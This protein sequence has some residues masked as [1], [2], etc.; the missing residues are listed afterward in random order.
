M[1]HKYLIGF[2]RNFPFASIISPILFSYR[3]I[4]LLIAEVN[5]T[6]W[7]SELAAIVFLRTL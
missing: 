2:D 4:A 1:K 3:V 5:I 7:A 6:S